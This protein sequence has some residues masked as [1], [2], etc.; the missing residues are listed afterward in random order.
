MQK[1]PH[2]A[3]KNDHQQTIYQH[4]LIG[5]IAFAD[6]SDEVNPKS[7]DNNQ[8]PEAVSYSAGYSLL[9]IPDSLHPQ[10]GAR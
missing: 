8:S 9:T 6:D 2:P 5:S 7:G 4:S 3:T 1:S 10:L